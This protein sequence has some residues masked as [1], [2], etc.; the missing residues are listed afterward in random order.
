MILIDGQKSNLALSNY[1]NL[2]EVLAKIVEEESLEKRI[3][4]DVLVNNKAFSEIYPH[5]AE[6]ISLSE[7][8]SLEL[9]TVSMEEMATDVV[10]EL[11]KVINIMASGAR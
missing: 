1:A 11:P 9:R 4:T 10:E 7:I 2:E 3:V 5:Q 8:S 6:D